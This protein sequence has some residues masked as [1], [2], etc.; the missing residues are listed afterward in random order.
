MEHLRDRSL[1]T[2]HLCEELLLFLNKLVFH[3][4]LLK[5]GETAPIEIN[6]FLFNGEL[7][8]SKHLLVEELV[9]HRHLLVVG[10][11]QDQVVLQHRPRVLIYLVRYAPEH[12]HTRIV[13]L[14][15]RL[16]AAK[17]GLLFFTLRL[18]ELLKL[19]ESEVEFLSGTAAPHKTVRL[20]RAISLLRSLKFHQ[21][22][23]QLVLMDVD[24]LASVHLHFYQVKLVRCD[25][26]LIAHDAEDESSGD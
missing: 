2:F 22:F 5:F 10:V 11:W 25:F 26:I 24:K 15:R 4:F 1:L 3:E 7:F 21:F 16:I 13:V 14:L 19:L 6:F 12:H 18:L 23:L 17:A 9:T 8:L 20:A